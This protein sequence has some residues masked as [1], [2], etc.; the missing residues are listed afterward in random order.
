[1]NKK[2]I[3]SNIFVSLLISSIV[4]SLVMLPFYIDW[5]NYREDFKRIN[6]IDEKH[7]NK[8]TETALSIIDEHYYLRDKVIFTLVFMASFCCCMIYPI[9]KPLF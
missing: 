8:T 6:H 2:I 1:M 4:G 9:K 5:T 3:I 7:L